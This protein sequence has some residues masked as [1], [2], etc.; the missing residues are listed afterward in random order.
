[1]H[2]EAYAEIEDDSSSDLSAPL[3]VTAAA[4]HGCFEILRHGGWDVAGHIQGVPQTKK[5]YGCWV[6]LCQT[7]V[8]ELP[9]NRNDRAIVGGS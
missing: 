9:E 7:S 5:M 6:G 2:S 4:G 8:G 3:V 1:M